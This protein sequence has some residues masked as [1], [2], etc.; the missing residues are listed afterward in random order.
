M[1]NEEYRKKQQAEVDNNY[2]AFEKILPEIIKSHNGEFA[3]M[4]KGGIKGYYSTREDARKAGRLAYK[5]NI[6]SIQEVTD[7]KVDLGYH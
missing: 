5:D 7:Q 2:A 6:F 1:D 3:L 4:K